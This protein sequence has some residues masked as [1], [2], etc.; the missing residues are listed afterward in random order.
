MDVRDTGLILRILLFFIVFLSWQ[1]TAFA[2][3]A[4]RIAVVY[5]LSAGGLDSVLRDMLAGL[6]TTPGMDLV[7]YPVSDSISQA[8]FESWVA[9]R[10]IQG[11]V[12]LGQKS[13][14]YTQRLQSSLPVVYGAISRAPEGGRGISMAGDPEQ[15]FS[16]LN[17]M[18]PRVK[19]V[20]TIYNDANTGWILPY[21][22]ES[23]ER[24]GLELVA[25]SA[26]DVR[27]AMNHLRNFLPNIRPDQDGLWLQIDGVVSDK[28]GVPMALETAWE[29][30]LVVISNS[31]LH[32]RR[33]AL[34]SFHP[35]HVAMGR[36]L[37]D[38][39]MQ[40]LRADLRPLTLPS[41]S[42]TL[43]VNERTAEH[44]GLT[45]YRAKLRDATFVNP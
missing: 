13:S 10:R 24:Y 42:L 18:A 35:D 26:R 43:T 40:S 25:Y 5:P 28:T 11:V 17:S 3:P 44:L 30:H 12:V 1:G 7:H 41:R 4:A 27:E 6:Q 37:G 16:L 14:S 8:E 15:F 2:A 9:A 23:A 36:R 38:M 19:R 22:R 21:A 29:R 34:F 31:P 20:Y 33:G 39:L 45:V 32:V